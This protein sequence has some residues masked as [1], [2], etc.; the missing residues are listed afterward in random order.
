MDYLSYMEMAR[1]NL[2]NSGSLIPVILLFKNEDLLGAL[3]TPFKDEKQKHDSLKAAG[4]LARK[5]GCDSVIFITDAAMRKFDNAQ[6]AEYARENWNTEA[7]LTYP[8]GS[9]VRVECICL[10]TLDFKTKEKTNTFQVYKKV[11][12]TPVFG[13]CTTLTGV[14]GGVFNSLEYGYEN[15]DCNLP[16]SILQPGE[17]SDGPDSD[18][19]N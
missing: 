8:E 5:N 6:Q 17:D 2:L 18:P 14:E 11:N 1:Q 10:A 19:L 12:N 13:E 15:P 16:V 9:G 3:L 4:I 7:P